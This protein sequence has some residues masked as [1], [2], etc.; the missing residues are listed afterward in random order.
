MNNDDFLT[1]IERDAELINKFLRDNLSSHV[2]L[3]SKVGS[4]ILLSGGKRLRPI[5]FVAASRMCNYNGGS[6]YYFSTVFE[7]LHAATLLHDD[8]VDNAAVRRGAQTANVLWNNSA[9]V[10]VGDF[11]YSKSFSM[12][13]EMGKI[14][15]LDVLSA[16]TNRMAEGM[17]LELIHTH[18]LALTE[19]EYLEIIICKT[20]ALLAAS[21][22][23][24][25][26]LGTATPEG[27]TALGKFGMDLGI[28]FQLVD[29]AL[30]YSLSEKQFGKPVGKDI[31]EGKI[32]FPLMHTLK[33]AS[34]TDRKKLADLAAKDK[35]SPERWPEAL[36]LVERYGGVQATLDK[37]RQYAD[38]AVRY[39][40][41]FPD[42]DSKRLMLELADFVVK[43]KL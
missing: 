26:M 19:E 15:I 31:E 20:A 14:A 32:T 17:V 30:D 28:A 24:G 13:V 25:G 43:R 42:S 23:I 5:L 34:E 21:A 18:N 10:L 2:R 22:K 4:H 8:V 29:D 33:V 36:E 1:K 12:A 38:G 3:I 39:L 11:L 27:Q 37:A 35:F 9:A 41:V 6:E 16:A 40:D 7:Y